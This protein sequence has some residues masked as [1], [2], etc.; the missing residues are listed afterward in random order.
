MMNRMAAPAV[1]TGKGL[2]GLDGAGQ[3]GMIRREVSELGPLFE[4]V[5]I[6][7]IAPRS[8]PC[9]CR[10]PCCSGK[11]QNREWSEAISFLADAART[12]ALSGCTSNGMMR[13]EYV[14]RYFTPKDHRVDLEKLAERFSINRDTVGAHNLKVAIW[15]GGRRKGK[16]VTPGVETIAE[17]AIEDCLRSLGVVE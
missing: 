4:A 17:N 11:A 2:A 1:G 9:P 10:R 7:R 14:V 8:M 5:L 3:A 15:L 6:A 12:N 13:R 16:D